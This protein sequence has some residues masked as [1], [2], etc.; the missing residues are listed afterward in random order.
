MHACAAGTKSPHSIPSACRLLL[1]MLAVGTK[2][3]YYFHE[4]I[5]RY[6]AGS[7]GCAREGGCTRPTRRA[8]TR[9]C[10]L[11]SQ[12]IKKEAAVHPRAAQRVLVRSARV[13]HRH[14][15]APLAAVGRHQHRC[16]GL[17][18]APPPWPAISAAALVCSAG[19][20]HHP[21][22]PWSAISATAQQASAITHRRP[23][24]S[25]PCYQS[26][27]CHPSNPCHRLPQSDPSRATDL[28]RRATDPS[29][30]TASHSP[31][32]AVPPLTI[33]ICRRCRLSNNTNMANS[34]RHAQR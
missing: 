4:Y 28:V 13:H 6:L 21:P 20:C 24:R 2:S 9:R 5:K 27:T 23:Y 1:H 8:R 26:K 32:Q 11:R 29:R 30:A 3:G 7:E 31:I 19:L 16:P 10:A 12:K 22:P 34:L 33:T 14:R 15:A 17:P 18:S 25:K